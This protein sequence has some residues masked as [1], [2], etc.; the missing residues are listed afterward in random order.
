MEKC[1]TNEK[2]ENLI[3]LFHFA[4]ACTKN[5]RSNFTSAIFQTRHVLTKTRSL[6]VANREN[7]RKLQRL[8]LKK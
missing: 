3:L 6:S 8:S 1:F 2:V 7:R 5:S 4:I